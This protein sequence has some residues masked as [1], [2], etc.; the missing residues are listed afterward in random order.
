MQLYKSR[1]FGEF[2]QDTFAF[3]K[4]NGSH[5]FKHFFIVNGIFIII[6]MVFSHYFSKF[7]S[8]LLFSN[9]ISEEQSSFESFMNENFGLFI[10]ICIIFVVVGLLASTISYAFVPIYL[11]LYNEHGSKNFGTNDIV[12]TYKAHIGQLITFVLCGILIAIPIA[13]FVGLLAFV[14]AVT[15]IGLIALPLVI[16]TVSLFYQGSLMEYL[17]QKRGI[18]ESFSY[19]WKLMSSKFWASVGCVGLFFLMNYIVQ[20]VIALVPSLSY[21]MD[22]IT[23][24]RSST[25]EPYDPDPFSNALTILYFII[26]FI[27]TSVLNAIVQINQGVI[28]YSLKEDNEHINTKSD[29]DLIGTSE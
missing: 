4:Q 17:E 22:V 1:G 9:L 5:F 10:L 16:G 25:F 27:I 7:Y 23:D 20:Y 24:S 6:L 12:N 28:F 14:L 26:T 11:K 8:D 15:I 3:I 19:N 18:W 2:F 13:I 21:F 29:I